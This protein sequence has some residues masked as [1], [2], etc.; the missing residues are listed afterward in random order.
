MRTLKDAPAPDEDQDGAANAVSESY[1]YLSKLMQGAGPG[2]EA[3]RASRYDTESAYD[4]DY[5]TANGATSDSDSSY[6]ERASRRRAEKEKQKRRKAKAKKEK[7]R[8][9]RDGAKNDCPHCKK[10]KRRAPHP[11]TPNEKCFWNK[12]YKGWRPKAV[13]DEMEMK[14]IPRHKLSEA[15]G[16]YPSDTDEE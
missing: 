1:S 5:E 14:F 15:M 2:D 16:G 6:G 9:R 12:E 13:C 3:S 7:E 11:K 8:G 10:Y 4:T